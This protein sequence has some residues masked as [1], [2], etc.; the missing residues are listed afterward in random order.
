[1]KLSEFKKLIN[2][3]EDNG[4]SEIMI[5]GDMNFEIKT[6]PILT[7]IDLGSD[8]NIIPSRAMEGLL[9]RA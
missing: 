3:L 2:E 1:M 7:N 6:C 4:E 9:G 5:L 8:Y